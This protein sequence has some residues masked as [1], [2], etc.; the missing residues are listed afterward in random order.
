MVGAPFP[1]SLGIGLPVGTLSCGWKSSIC[2][3]V[4]GERGGKGETKE[5]KAKNNTILTTPPKETI[6]DSLLASKKYIYIYTYRLK[7]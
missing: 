4:G 1:G 6:Y 7:K 5:S 3:S 2:V